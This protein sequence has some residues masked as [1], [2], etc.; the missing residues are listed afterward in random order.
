ME[1]IVSIISTVGFPIA[2]CIGLA[3]FMYKF[4]TDAQEAN[5]EREDKYIE[6]IQTVTPELKT[7]SENL[8]VVK[9]NVNEIL[10]KDKQRWGNS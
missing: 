10:E 8:A 1:N 3:Y 9:D 6:I 2:A 5:K 4:F 7:I